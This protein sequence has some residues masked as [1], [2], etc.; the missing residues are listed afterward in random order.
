M[1][2]GK[3]ITLVGC[4]VLMVVVVYLWVGSIQ[5]CMENLKLTWYTCTQ[6]LQSRGG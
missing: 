1:T 3:W 6:L 2:R 4:L 5:D